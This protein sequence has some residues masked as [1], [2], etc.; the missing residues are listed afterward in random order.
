[1]SRCDNCGHDAVAHDDRAFIP[2]ITE[3]SKPTRCWCPGYAT[4][5]RWKTR[6]PAA[7]S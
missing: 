3:S 1:M 4:R 6:E 7:Q 5:D 2:C